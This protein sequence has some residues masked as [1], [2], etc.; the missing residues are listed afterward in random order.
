MVNVVR[1]IGDFNRLDHLA[2]HAGG[3]LVQVFI[4]LLKELHQA[5]FAIL[6]N[7][8]PYRDDR[9]VFSRHA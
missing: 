7:E 6:A 4:D 9:L 1:D 3:N 5:V 8:K 2:G